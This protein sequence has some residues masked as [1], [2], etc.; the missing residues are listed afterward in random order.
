MA[1]GTHD[2]VSFLSRVWTELC[3]RG[4]VSG[5]III[6]N[7]FAGLGLIFLNSDLLPVYPDQNY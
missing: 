3:T 5:T 7:K 4:S 1:M 6:P 2:P